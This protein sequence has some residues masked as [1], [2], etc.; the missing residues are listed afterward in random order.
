M[1]KRIFV[2]TRIDDLAKECQPFIGKVV[3]VKSWHSNFSM[4]K[5]YPND[6]WIGYIKEFN[7]DIPESELLKITPSVLALFSKYFLSVP[8]PII[9][10][11]KPKLLKASTIIS[12]LL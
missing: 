7:M 12:T 3:T 2:P 5:N 8:S 10:N 1:E 9:F 4:Q 11:G 6:I